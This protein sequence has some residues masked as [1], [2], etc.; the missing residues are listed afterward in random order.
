MATKAATP[1]PQRQLRSLTFV[2]EYLGV[3]ER[4]VR[5]Y[6]AAGHLKAYRLTLAIPPVPEPW[7]TARWT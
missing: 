2:A 7:P 5:R 1:A 6:V 3:D 4:T